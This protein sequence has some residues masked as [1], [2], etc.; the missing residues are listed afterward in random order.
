[1]RSGRLQAAIAAVIATGVA[2]VAL[3]VVSAQADSNSAARSSSNVTA[4]SQSR[5][6]DSATCGALTAPCATIAQGVT[7]ARPGQTVVVGPG[8]YKELVV[9]PKPLTLDGNGATIDASGLTQGSGMSMDAAGVLVLPT[10]SGST[11]EGLRITGANG[12][13]ILIM[14]A[15]GVRVEHNKVSG[16]DLGAPPAS[17][18]FECQPQGQVPG[19]CGEG[20]HLMSATDSQVVGNNVT[21]NAGG[22]LVTDELGPA[23][24][25]SIANNYVADNLYD[26]GITMPSHSTNAVD[27]SGNLHP[28]LGGVY[29]NTVSG[30]RIFGNGVLGEGA[31]VLIAAAGPGGASYNNQ[32]IGNVISGNEMSGVTIHSHAPNQDVSGNT[33]AGNNIGPNN[34]GGD[35]DFP[36]P[37]T[38]GIL[39][40]SAVVPVSVT[41]GHNN[42]HGNSVDVFTTTNVTVN[43]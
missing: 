14:S 1:M 27:A 34:L 39:V 22:I 3:P 35:P 33:I 43:K 37:A 13:G 5:G 38:T 7:N 40:G 26:C 18:Y 6:I 31:G 9:I 15:S 23:H 12:E 41:I 21:G 20:I 29:D 2:S 25:N 30:N 24:D 28:S 19:D 17:S 8:T 10:A 16:N 11:I 4:V 36:D 42:I 32:I